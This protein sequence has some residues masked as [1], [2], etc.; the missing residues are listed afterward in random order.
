MSTGIEI[1]PHQHGI[2]NGGLRSCD[3]CAKPCSTRRCH[4]CSVKSA[5]EDVHGWWSADGKRYLESSPF[6]PTVITDLRT[7]EEKARDAFAEALLDEPE[8]KL[9][10][11]RD[12]GHGIHAHSHA[13]ADPGNGHTFS[14]AGSPKNAHAHAYADGGLI[15]QAPTHSHGD[16]PAAARFNPILGLWVATQDMQWHE[17]LHVLTSP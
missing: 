16:V 8:F 12:H 15:V 6:G 7:D 2:S 10:D 3:R 9:P 11:L 14:C 13:L 1:N 17:H 4:E 5:T